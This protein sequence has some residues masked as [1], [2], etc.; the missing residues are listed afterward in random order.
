MREHYQDLTLFL[1]LFL[2]RSIRSSN[3]TVRFRLINLQGTSVFTRIQEI[4]TQIWLYSLLLPSGITQLHTFIY[5]L[6][7][8]LTKALIINKEGL[9]DAGLIVS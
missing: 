4:D 6:L 7:N 2:S 9:E 3:P 5:L 8:L 1:L